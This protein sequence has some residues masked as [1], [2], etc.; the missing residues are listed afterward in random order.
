MGSGAPCLILI[1]LIASNWHLRTTDEERSVPQAGPKGRRYEEQCSSEGD[2][3]MPVTPSLTSLSTG[4]HLLRAKSVLQEPPTTSNQTTEETTR[5]EGGQHVGDIRL[6]LSTT[7]VATTTD[8]LPEDDTRQ[9]PVLIYCS[10][11]LP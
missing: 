1:A 5:I 8:Q 3:Q 4:I 9:D 10:R 2:E 7:S 6:S 11:H